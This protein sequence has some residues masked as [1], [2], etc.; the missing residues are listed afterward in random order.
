MKRILLAGMVTVLGACAGPQ[1]FDPLPFNAAE[2][3]ALPKAGTS[4]VRGQVFMKTRGGGVKK[5]A[6]SSVI[7]S[8]ATSTSDQAY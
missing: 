8:P 4:V 3:E 5:G 6:G 1:T 7:L 2:Y